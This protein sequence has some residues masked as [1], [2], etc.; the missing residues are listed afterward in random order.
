MHNNWDWT[1]PFEFIDSV[2]FLS[3]I[4]RMK[5]SQLTEQKFYN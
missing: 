4:H 5:S 3:L 1:I 2:R